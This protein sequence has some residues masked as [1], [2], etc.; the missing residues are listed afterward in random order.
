M[1]FKNYYHDI[2]Y[3]KENFHTLIDKVENKELLDQF[4]KALAFS[5]ERKEGVL[6][7]SLNEKE[8]RMVMKSYNDTENRKNLVSHEKVMENIRNI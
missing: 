4:Y 2:N 6:W 8:K 5:A 7:N 1:K 3:I